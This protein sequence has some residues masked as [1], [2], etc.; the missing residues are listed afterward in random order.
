MLRRTKWGAYY[1][2]QAPRCARSAGFLSQ[3]M[4]VPWTRQATSCSCGCLA[5]V[6][7]EPK[8]WLKKPSALMKRSAISPSKLL[9]PSVVNDSLEWLLH[10][11]GPRPQCVPCKKSGPRRC[12]CQAQGL[13]PCLGSVRCRRCS[14]RAPT[15]HLSSL[16]LHAKPTA[17]NGFCGSD[18]SG[19]CI[20]Y[21]K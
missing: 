11:A 1:R 7:V 16:P 12:H 3:C 17:E 15:K 10:G 18:R 4:T 5:V 21:N 14:G 2:S 19:L 13:G 8:G 6:T 20:Q 9:L